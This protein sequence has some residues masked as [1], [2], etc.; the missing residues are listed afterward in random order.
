MAPPLVEPDVDGLVDWLVVERSCIVERS[1]V[2]E[3]AAGA[4]GR[5]CVP[6]A[7]PEPGDDGEELVCAKAGA[8]SK[9]VARR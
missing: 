5:L 4:A 6:E 8:A 2:A 3:G 9:V 1:C 7:P